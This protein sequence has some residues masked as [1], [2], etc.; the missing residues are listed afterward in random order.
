MPYY[1]PWFSAKDTHMIYECGS[2]V[3]FVLYTIYQ[4][5]E[6]KLQVERMRATLDREHSASEELQQKLTHALELKDKEVSEMKSQLIELRHTTTSFTRSRSQPS[7]SSSTAS[8]SNPGPEAIDS[9]QLHFL[10]QAV[11]HL[12]TDFH[13]EDQLRAVVSLLNFSPQERKAVYAKHDRKRN[14]RTL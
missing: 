10:K 6:Q 9:I 2:N 11:Y 14:P 13:A 12:L 3:T 7:S 5:R 4:V 1:S 8:D